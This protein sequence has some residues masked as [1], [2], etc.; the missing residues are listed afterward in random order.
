MQ[1]IVAY[2]LILAGTLSA[3]ILVNSEARKNFKIA[4]Y[5]NFGVIQEV[6]KVS[7]PN[8]VNRIRFDNVAATIKPSSAFLQWSG[9]YG[10]EILAQSYEYDLLSPL[11]LLEKFIGKELEIVPSKG[12]W[13]DTVPQ[14]AELIS[15]NG[16]EP[17]FRI[18]T[19]IT[20]GQIGQILFPYMPENLITRPTLIW[21]INSPQRQEVDLTAT[22]LADDI[23]WSAGYTVH[24]DTKDNTCLLNSVIT[25]KNNSGMDCVNAA[26]TLVAGNV[27]RYDA[28][29]S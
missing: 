17:V 9:E 24:V 6:R 3:D 1:R 16:D 29:G 4:I 10:I 25:V 15:I 8:G 14:R 26:A 12:N 11:K 22:Y 23:S 28:A 18:G 7:P 2:I 27:D 21:D 19:K 5:Q 20:F 13:P